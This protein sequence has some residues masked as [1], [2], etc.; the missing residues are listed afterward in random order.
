MEQAILTLFAIIFGLIVIAAIAM[1][2]FG[3]TKRSALDTERYRST[4]KT[5]ET[6]SRDGASGR[7]LAVVNA[8]KLLDAAMR[9]LGYRGQTMGDRLKQHRT[10]FSD[11]NGIWEAH[12]LRNRIA[13]ETG[14]EVTARDT[15]KALAQLQR[16]LK[17]LGAL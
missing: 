15:D 17:D 12:K 9:D 5:I 14:I 13:H 10:S 3:G 7:Q 2:I 6:Q 16:G 11:L 8:D 1:K 4:W